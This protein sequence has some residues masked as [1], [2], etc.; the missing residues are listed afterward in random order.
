MGP[1]LVPL[2]DFVPAATPRFQRPQHLAPVAALLERTRVEP[3]RA[4][5]SA[6]PRMGKTEILQHGVAWRLLDNPGLRVGYATY[7][8]RFSEKRSAKIRA[9]HGRVGG[10]ID[11][12]ARSKSD[13]R[14]GVDDGGVWATSVGGAI[15][16]EGF[17]L[18]LIDDP[19]KGRAE[20]ESAIER[21]KVYAW[22]TDDAYTRLE[23]DASAIVFMARWHEDDLAGRLIRDGW[24][25]VVLPAIDLD[26]GSLW[27]ER[28]PVARLR[29]IEETLGPY[30]WESLYQGRPLP[31][32]GALFRDV[33]CYD[34]LPSTFRIGKGIDLSYSGKT[35]SDQSAAV[36]LFESGGVFYVVDVRTARVK[37]PEFM[38]VLA[39][40]DRTHPGPW[41]WYTSST[42]TGVA[43]IATASAGVHIVSERAGVDKY[44]RAQ[45]IAA[46]W[47][48]GRVLLPRSAP[49]LDAF[50]SEVCGFTGV[51]DR[52]DDQVDALASA[53]VRAGGT[54][55]ARSSPALGPS[56][57][58]TIP[59]AFGGGA[60]SQP[61]LT[62]L[63]RANSA[64]PHPL[65]SPRGGGG[66]GRGGGIW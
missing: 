42:E 5:V 53:F 12:D 15:V 7:G 35:R 8:Q 49:W 60:S 19:H 24:D 52:H 36:V 43:E 23:P 34:A 14:T 10:P 16:G 58:A 47:N 51:G 27:P 45:G 18:L 62:A 28:W 55:A 37:V 61:Q 56:R 17:D 31:R 9:I 57:F 21:D 50:I 46:A 59:T 26:G 22:F 63:P 38:Q 33:A 65:A 4:V 6:P 30:S 3:V 25:H 40:V 32:G 13:W 20:V 1:K 66:W 64:I 41:H 2:L 54:F 48:A 29:A 11:D 39:A 44:M